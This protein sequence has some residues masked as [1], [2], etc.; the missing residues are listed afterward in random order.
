MGRHSAPEDDED[1]GDVAVAVVDRSLKPHPLP[2]PRG[3]HSAPDD[4]DAADD[5]SIAAGAGVGAGVGIEAP[6]RH[7]PR[8]VPVAPA[9]E[10][11]LEAVPEAGPQA[12]VEPVLKTDSAPAA[13]PDKPAVPKAPKAPKASKLPK[14]R[15]DS[16]TQQDLAMLRSDPALRNRVAAAV[17]VPFALTAVVLTVVGEL[18]SFFD[19]IWIPLISAGVLAG[20]L[21]DSA[22]RRIF[23]R[24]AELPDDQAVLGGAEGVQAVTDVIDAGEVA[25]S[26]RGAEPGVGES[27][28]Q[29]DE[30]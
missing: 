17:V 27:P 11:G 26:K 19:W 4:D 23:D 9:A 5:A 18:G 13:K 25:G 7:R 8:P 10:A 30:S 3:R 16:A 29:V 20:L 15:G 1:A 12:A 6:A 24:A 2:V 14:Q 28:G 22:Q 21:L